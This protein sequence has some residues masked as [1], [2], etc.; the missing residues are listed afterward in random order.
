MLNTRMTAILR[1]L[2]GAK[3]CIT[4][5]ELAAAIEVTSRTIRNDMKELDTILSEHGGTIRSKRGT[6]YQ[7]LIENEQSF[8]HFLKE[9]FQKNPERDD[10]IPSLPE[11]R[12]QYLIRRLLL[13]DQYVKLENLADEMFISKSTIQNDLRDV[14]KLLDLYGIW[15]EKR[16]NYGIRLQGDEVNLR[17]CMSE[18]IFNRAGTHPD[19]NKL[20]VSILTAEEMQVIKHIILLQIKEH[21]IALSDISLNNLVIHIAIAYKRIQNSNFVSLNPRQLEEIKNQMEYKVAERIIQNIEDKLD[22]RFPEA[23]IAYIAIHL[24]G[25]RTMANLNTEE[26]AM[27]DTTDPVIHQLSLQIMEQVEEKLGLG[28][29]DDQELLIS[30]SLHLKPALYRFRYKM[31]LR[32]P[33]L[34]QIKANY[35]IA[36]EGGII[37]GIVIKEVMDIDINEHEIG[38]IALHIGAAMERRTMSSIPKKCLIICASG[39]GSARLLSYKLQ[40]VFG[41]KIIIAGTIEYYKLQDFPIHTVDFII[42]TIP[43][44]ESIPVPVIEVNTFLGNNDFQKIESQLKTNKSGT[45]SYTTEELV[46]LQK[47]F[48]TREEV[49]SFLADRLNNLGLA[50]D[51]FLESVLERESFSPTS[52]GNLVAIPHPAIPQTQ[53]TFWAVCTL[54]K[55]IKWGD[56]RVQFVCLLSV[57]KNSRGDFQNMYNQLGSILDDS[58]KVQQFLKCKTYKEFIKVLTE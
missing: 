21:C 16:P 3:S 33:M 45:T 11:E 20:G 56:K 9:N 25:T 54:Q 19:I 15:L 27:H 4:G 17:Y 28:I 5:E 55:P 44:S 58:T 22:V 57:E 50:D 23:E 10:N 13:S 35:P 18:Y 42:S 14:K 40:S 53:S 6:G 31:N 48:E 36:F 47:K 7:L 49:L 38:Y 46:F 29:I 52:F 12:V 30:L 37:A 8:L 34:N 43:I 51:S 26:A 24:L 2:M 41:T 39:L 32:N 1:E